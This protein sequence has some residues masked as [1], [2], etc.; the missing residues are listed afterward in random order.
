MLRVSQQHHAANPA[1]AAN[2][3]LRSLHI[4]HRMP[5]ARAHH[6]RPGLRWAERALWPQVLLVSQF[7]LYYRCKGA[8]L[9]FSKSMPPDA[10]RTFYKEFVERV[11]TEYGDPSRVHDGRSRPPTPPSSLLS[12]RPLNP[13]PPPRLPLPFPCL[14]L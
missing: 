3:W 2:P 13:F 6:T 5:R 14:W 10:A 9:D 11:Q 8:N 1:T 7:T 4:H 12:C